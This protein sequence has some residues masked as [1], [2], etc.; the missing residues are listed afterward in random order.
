LSLASLLAGPGDSPWMVVLL[1]LLIDYSVSCTEPSSTILGI[2][3]IVFVCCRSLFILGSL[4]F[5]SIHVWRPAVSVPSMDFDDYTKFLT[6]LMV[7][8]GSCLLYLRILI[9]NCHL[10]SWSRQ[11]LHCLNPTLWA[12]PVSP[13]VSTPKNI[14][15]VPSRFSSCSFVF[16]S[17][18]SRFS[19]SFVL[20]WVQFL[21]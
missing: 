11:R 13:S 3:T 21:L 4:T 10:F 18:I 2:E 6:S 14:Q 5:C 1:N 15:T 8:H 9:C 7:L 17:L 16:R 12:S 19:F 20:R